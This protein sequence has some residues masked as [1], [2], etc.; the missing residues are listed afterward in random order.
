MKNFQLEKW[1]F[2]SFNKKPIKNWWFDLQGFYQ[3]ST[4]FVTFFF[5]AQ[6]CGLVIYIFGNVGVPLESPGKNRK[7]GIRESTYS[8]NQKVLKA[9]DHL[10]G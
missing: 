1:C 5:Q 9:T 4:I 8:L 3:K 10:V 2:F 6:G 7:P